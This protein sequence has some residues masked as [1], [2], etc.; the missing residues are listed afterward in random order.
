MGDSEMPMVPRI[1]A[2]QVEFSK[3]IRS[4]VGIKTVAVGGITKP[5]QA[6][7]I[8]QAGDADLIALARELL[9]NADWPSHSAKVLGLEDPFAYLPEGY[10][11]RLRLRESQKEMMINQDKTEITK[12]LSYFL[13]NADASAD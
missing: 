4:A 3:R 9:W 8:L 2:Y 11:H 12:S 5:K 1:P 6:E 10:A 13:S 7:D